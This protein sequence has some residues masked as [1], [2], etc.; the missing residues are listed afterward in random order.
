MVLLNYI[1]GKFNILKELFLY[2]LEQLNF[3]GNRVKTEL[4]HEAE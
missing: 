3:A 1:C 4:W 2:G